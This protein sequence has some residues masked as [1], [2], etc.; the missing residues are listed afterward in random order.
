M[1]SKPFNKLRFIRCAIICSAFFITV[2]AKAQ[3]WHFGP[4]LDV[5]YSNISG[6]GMK[7]SFSPGWQIG[8]FAE[9]VLTKSWSIQP[10]L[11]YSWSRYKKSDDFI[12]YYV[13]SGRS[14]AGTNINLASISV[15]LLL[16]YNVNKTLSFL[17]GPQYSYLVFDDEALLKSDRQA[18]K[19]NEISAN[20]GVQVNLQSVG[21][22]ARFNKGLS[23]INDID[24]RYKWRSNH[25]Q[26]GVAVKLR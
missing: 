6:N 13:N 3:S 24:E 7:K 8:A 9:I 4:K 17:A 22:Y 19:K 12:T 14:T 26:V 25:I 15:P 1:T 18:F 16:R 2:T 5:N 11:L 21:F 10:E 23:D 20:A